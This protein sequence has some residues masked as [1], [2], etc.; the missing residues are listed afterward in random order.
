MSTL[1]QLFPYSNETRTAAN[2]FS[3]YCENVSNDLINDLAEQHVKYSV[4]TSN[5][6]NL[7]ILHTVKEDDVLKEILKLKYKKSVGVDGISTLILKHVY[8]N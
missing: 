8:M 3:C 4:N 5:P 7:F 2:I 1:H 6:D